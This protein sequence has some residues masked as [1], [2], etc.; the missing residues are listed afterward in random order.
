M[1][2]GVNKLDLEGYTTST[3]QIIARETVSERS[4][5]IVFNNESQ[6]TLAHVVGL[7]VKDSTHS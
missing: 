2:H 7:S 1:L 4:T 6:I 3:K 5:Y